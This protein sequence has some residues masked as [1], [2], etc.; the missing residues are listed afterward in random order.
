MT[1]T[2]SRGKYSR[3]STCF[4]NPC[5]AYDS[6]CSFVRRQLRPFPR[7]RRTP[8]DPPTRPAYQHATRACSKSTAKPRMAFLEGTKAS[9]LWDILTPPIA[10]QTTIMQKFIA[11]FSAKLDKSTLPEQGLELAYG[12]TLLMTLLSWPTLPSTVVLHLQLTKH[13]SPF[14]TQNLRRAVFFT[15]FTNG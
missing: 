9:R 1:P 15:A 5:S 8:A 4:P 10:R 11:V 14:S 2:S 3:V 7:L 13:S 6:N 12:I